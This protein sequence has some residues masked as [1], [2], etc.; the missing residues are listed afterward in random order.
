[1]R[2]NIAMIAAATAVAVSSPAF[3]AS[4]FFTSFDSVA[5]AAGGYVILPTVEGWMAT[6]G[7]GIELQNS[8]AGAPYSSPNLV[9]LD[10]DNNTV[11]S[12]TIEAGVYTLSFFYSP[13]PNIGS[14]SNGIQY[15]VD[16]VTTGSF[17]ANGGGG[18]SWSQQT[19]NFTAFAPTTLRFAA[20]GTSDSFG[21]YVD[22][23][24][25]VG[26]AVPEAATWGMMVLGFGIAGAATRRR[27]RM[28][29]SLV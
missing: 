20:I 2:K 4:N 3:A 9:E 6:S 17:T 23:I 11:M 1:M 25:L 5:V 27:R 19:I 14:G 29:A 26:S 10:S 18:T 21:G 12:R 13:R 28:V 7:A 24:R 16:G 8:A 22:D 15:I